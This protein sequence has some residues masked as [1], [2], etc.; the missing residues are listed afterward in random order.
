MKI[1][2]NLMLT[3]CLVGL[4]AQ[5]AWGNLY[6]CTKL[7][8]STPVAIG[9][10]KD[11]SLSVAEAYVQTAVS[12]T[13]SAPDADG[14]VTYSNFSGKKSLVSSDSSQGLKVKDNGTSADVQLISSSGQIWWKDTCA[15]FTAA[16]KK[17]FTC[18]STVEKSFGP[19]NISDKS[20]DPEIKQIDGGFSWSQT[21][22]TLGTTYTYDV[23]TRTR[24]L[25]CEL[26]KYEPTNCAAV[27]AQV[28]DAKA[29]KDGA[30]SGEP[31]A[32]KVNE[33]TY[34]STV[35]DEESGPWYYVVTV[36]PSGDS[37]K[38]KKIVK[39]NNPDA[40]EN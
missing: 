27:V 9:I 3:I 25:F 11:K 37:C 14:F 2:N 30:S 1:K 38:F 18:E 5:N 28:T 29:Y 39:D 32:K 23:T 19:P 35:D 26:G 36:Q 10:K 15:K 16:D 4:T 13:R 40:W 17:S 8:S 12:K 24:G 22:S 31:S 34:K 21:D 6:I 7:G 20:P 33:T